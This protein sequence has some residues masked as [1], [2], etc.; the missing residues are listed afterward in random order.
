MKKNQ[1]SKLAL[2]GLATGAMI[3]NTVTLSANTVTESKGTY[4]AGGCG[5]GGKCSGSGSNNSNANGGNTKNYTADT[6]APASN[7]V[8]NPSMAPKPESMQNIPTNGQNQ[9]NNQGQ[10]MGTGSCAAKPNAQGTGHSGS[11]GGATP[12][13]GQGSCASSKAPAA[14][15]HS[16]CGGSSTANGQRAGCGARR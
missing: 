3:A 13:N 9:N 11:C 5:G 10:G 14:P 6:F 12:S 8:V 4:L 2:M 1:L 7:N 16:S 15:S